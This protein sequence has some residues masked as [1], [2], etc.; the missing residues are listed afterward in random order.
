VQRSTA[1]EA[2]NSSE[3]LSVG[4]DQ[5]FGQAKIIPPEAGSRCRRLRTGSR[6]SVSGNTLRALL[7]MISFSPSCLI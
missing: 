6:S 3:N 1:K 4:L 2:G 5:K 7:R